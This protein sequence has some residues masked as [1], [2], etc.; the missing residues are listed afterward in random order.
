M[1]RY[2]CPYI[3]GD[4]CSSASDRYFD[5][6]HF[7]ESLHPFVSS[8]NSRLQQPYIKIGDFLQQWN[9]NV[10]L[11]RPGGPG[12]EAAQSLVYGLINMLPCVYR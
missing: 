2:K 3:A 12:A 7:S 11:L 9:T 8:A 5:F 1:E 10:T 4:T 6:H